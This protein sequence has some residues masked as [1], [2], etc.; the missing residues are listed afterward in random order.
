MMDYTFERNAS[1]ASIKAGKY[2]NIRL[3]YGPMNFDFATN[4]TDIWVINADQAG[5]AEQ[6]KN[7][8]STGGWRFPRN[9]VNPI[10][11]GHNT[12]PWYL[13]TE[14]GRMYATCWYTFEA[15]TDSMVAAGSGRH[16]HP[17][18]W[19]R[20]P[21]AGPRLRSGLSGKHRGRARTSRAARMLV[22]PPPL[23][24][25][26]SLSHSLALLPFLPP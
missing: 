7:Q 8:L 24:F 13:A 23:F 5:D 10:P 15:L 18:G 16:R 17:L 11:D 12:P 4:R 2:D 22:D 20:W 1:I 14:F 19:W 9:L 21:W 26:L 6:N 25:S 3:F